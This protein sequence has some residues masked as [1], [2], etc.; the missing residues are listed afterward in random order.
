MSYITDIQK[1]F[2]DMG[3][4]LAAGLLE[5]TEATMFCRISRALRRFL[6]KR[7]MP[8]Y[9]GEILY[10]CGK[11]D[12]GIKVRYDYGYTIAVE[13][14]ELRKRDMVAATVLERELPAYLLD[15]NFIQPLPLGHSVGG[16]MFTHSIPNFK[17]I[18]TEGL[19]SYQK[20]VEEMKDKDLR[21]GLLDVLE[22]IRSFHG[23]S[24]RLL[25]REGAPAQ[26]YHA[27]KK[28]PFAPADTLYEALV[29][30]NFIYYMDGCDKICDSIG[31]MDADLIEF[32]RGEDMTEVF[33]CFFRNVDANDGWSGALG[34]EYNALTLQILRASKGIRRP[35][36]E[37]RVTP[38]MP[39]EI[40]EAAM[41]SVFSGSGN[42]CF[43]NETG[44]QNALER[45]FPEI[46]KEDRLKFCGC[47]CTETMLAGISNVGSLDAGVNIAWIFE[48]IMRNELPQAEDF[49]VF[50]KKF[51]EECHK[52]INKVF[53]H[54]SIC[55]R[56]RA[57]LR[58]QPMRTLLMDDCIEKEKDFNN[59]G[60]RYYWSIV[61]LAGMINVIDSLLVIRYL[62]FD[63]KIMDG[64]TLLEK[65]D[66]GENFAGYTQIPRHGMDN[67]IANEMAA[68][69]SGD[70]CAAYEGKVPYLGGKFLPAS[71][72]HITY[73]GAGKYVGATPDG[74]KAG[75]PLCDSIG[76]IHGND[77]N[78][79]TALLNSAA[80]LDQKSMAGTP[81]LNVK[82]TPDQ[83]GDGLQTLVNGYFRKGGMQMQ[84]TCVRK[85]DLLEAQ[86]NPEKYQNLIVRTGGYS[87]YFVRLSEEEQQTIIERTAHSI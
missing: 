69:V 63:K 60:A 15:P 38:Q 6:E 23:R 39:K 77:R 52:V 12:T 84:I 35:S 26:L 81:V 29:C 5:E 22:G 82:L 33:R 11:I 57:Q 68:R 86:K 66:A 45:Y 41:D 30:W 62:V 73:L 48:E 51:M 74:R 4:Y 24:L 3:E 78:G 83:A 46:P 67:E 65:L 87:A 32:Y 49:E 50:Y 34:P 14:E 21:Q 16:N 25:E 75:E 61:N 31:R 20:R 13:W 1:R 58:P 43:Y 10:P 70:L 56:Q 28:V 54:I 9:H 79:I 42:P 44:Y 7:D 80:A 27:L 37:L 47:G 19:D 59:G 40:W 64:T 36:I 55:Q 53:E 2:E 18:I 76:A 71:I 72:Q 17:R 85:E 8:A